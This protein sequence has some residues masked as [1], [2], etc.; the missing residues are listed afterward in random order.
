MISQGYTDPDY[1]HVYVYI[2][3]WCQNIG[4]NQEPW[5]MTIKESARTLHVRVPSSSLQPISWPHKSPT[6]RTCS[7]SPALR[8][9]SIYEEQ[10]KRL[11]CS[12]GWWMP[13][14]S[15]NNISRS[16][17]FLKYEAT[18]RKNCLFYERL[19]RGG[20]GPP[21]TQSLMKTNAM[22]GRCCPVSMFFRGSG[23]TF[24]WWWLPRVYSPPSYPVG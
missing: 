7:F 23:L 17:N 19:G 8:P 10:I 4:M 6:H 5:D 20:G 21:E 12:R 13:A 9:A 22:T 18:P 1:H 11:R 24:I 16:S 3:C 15:D 2:K 14:G